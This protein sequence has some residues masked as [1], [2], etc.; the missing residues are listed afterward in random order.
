MGKRLLRPLC[1]LQVSFQ[2]GA[3]PA[4]PGPVRPGRELEEQPL[5][6]QVFVMQELEV[7]DRLAPP[8][9]SSKFL[10]LHTSERMPRRTHSNMVRARGHRTHAHTYT[11]RGMRLCLPQPFG[12]VPEGGGTGGF[13]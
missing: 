5:S 12:Q 13:H 1:A 6:R 2:H 9:R 3:Y 8:P 10:Y 11:H 4:E 7:R